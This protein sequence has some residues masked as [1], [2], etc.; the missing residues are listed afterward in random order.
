MELLKVQKVRPQSLP[1]EEA[2]R[3]TSAKKQLTVSRSSAESEYRSVAYAV[4]ESYWLRQLLRDLRVFLHRPVIVYR[5]NV[6]A[7]YLAANP[8]FHARTKHIEID[9]HFVREKVASGDIVV[10]YVSTSDQL[11]DIFTKGLS[12]LKFHQLKGIL[13]N[14]HGLHSKTFELA[15]ECGHT[16]WMATVSAD[17]TP[18]L[19]T[20]ALAL[21]PG[22]STTI[23]LPASWSGCIWGRTFCTYDAIGRF[24]CATGDCDSSSPECA[25]AS[26]QPPVTMAEFKLSSPG[27]LDFYVVSAWRGYNLGMLVV[28]HGG[29]G[30]DCMATGCVK[31]VEGFC[32]PEP[33][34]GCSPCFG[35]SGTKYCCSGAYTRPDTCKPSPY[36]QY[37]KS[38]CP[39]S[40]RYANDDG[41]STRKFDCA[42]SH[43]VITFCPHPSTGQESS[44]G[45]VSGPF[46]VKT[47]K[48][49]VMARFK[50]S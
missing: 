49:F 42:S 19:F 29:S 26:A 23:S 22:K 31:D 27:Y 41:K 16:V 38:K 50:A 10:R 45:A 8:V 2:G 34:G 5:D 11:A 25:C 43:Y 30:G 17:G 44:T 40:Y 20:D 24:T 9:F 39:W 32:N 33:S 28:P 47:K 36:S 14:R 21:L 35:Y 46:G 1:D 3:E 18:P 37:F 7:T 4:A 12:R 48:L 15:N 13:N 6:S